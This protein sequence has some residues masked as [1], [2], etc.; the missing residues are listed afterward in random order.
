METMIK[1]V[2]KGVKPSRLNATV[3]SGQYAGET[4]MLCQWPTRPHRRSN[5]TFDCVH[6]S[7]SVATFTYDFS[8]FK[9]P[10]Y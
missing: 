1:W 5:T 10:V 8:A 2:E 7:K 6:D 9:V 3:S 4:Q